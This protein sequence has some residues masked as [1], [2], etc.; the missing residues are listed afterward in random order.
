V[1][2]RACE[3]CGHTKPERLLESPR[4]DG[5]L[6]RCPRCGLVYVGERRRDFTF[7]AADPSRTEALGDL[8][9]R[10]GIVARD[11]E[12]AEGPARL[13]AERERVAHLKR[14]LASGRL[15]DVGS[16]LGSFLV[17]AAGAGFAAE[18]VEPDPG[19][20]EQA[21][22][23]G[24]A[25]RTGTLDDLAAGPRFDVLTMFHVIEHLDSPR[26]ALE[27]AR[28]LARPGATLMIETPTVENLWFR[29][30][31]G[32]WRQLIPDHYFFFSRATLERLLRQTGFRP[33]EH[34][35]VGRRVTLRFA[36]DRLRRAGVPG[37]QLAGRAVAAAG[38]GERTLHLNPGD[39]MRVVARAV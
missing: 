22:A 21:R 35:S 14:H 20:A 11:V 25:V 24:L 7:S 27:R 2:V 10:L 19:T 29:L 15:L 30:A 1:N 37:A 34:R 4:L 16:A 36:A 17:V 18:G 26:A 28:A 13:E 3:V 6:V 8:V 38:L 12:A 31:P 9:D 39:I 5:P 33:V 23:R 32:R